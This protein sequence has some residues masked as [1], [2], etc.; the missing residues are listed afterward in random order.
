MAKKMLT[1]K[2][3]DFCVKYFEL[4]NVGEAARLAKYSPKT[5]DVIGRENLQKPIIRE[6]IAELRKMKA[7]ASI[8]TVQERQQILTEIARGDLLDYQEVGADGAYLNIGKDSPN[9]KAISEITSRTEYNKDSSSA[10]IVTRV[11]LHNPVPAIAELNKMDG[12]YNDSSTVNVNVTEAKVVTFDT[13]KVAAAIFE[14]IR[15]GFSPE[16]LGRNGHSEDA[17]LLP[18]PT[19]GETTPLSESQN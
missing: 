19:N 16:I 11:K 2:Q 12:V 8:A 7:D 5:A 9:T 18:A 4:G 1:Q 3:E 17:A 6:R 15:L 14:A 10:A 13:G